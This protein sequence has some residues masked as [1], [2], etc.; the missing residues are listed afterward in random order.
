MR[1]EVLR[2]LDIDGGSSISAILDDL[3]R[4]HPEPWTSDF[5]A[6]VG[7]GVAF[8]TFAYD[9]D[10]VSMEIAKYA[11][12]FEHLLPGVPIHC[13]AGTFGDKADVV[14]DRSWRRFEL[15]GADGWD[16]WD[17]GKWFARLFYE[18]LPADSQMSSELAREMW[19]QALVLAEQLV[20]YIEDHEIGLLF[21]VNTNS[22]PGNLAFGLA[23]VLAAET[24]GRVVI[25][26]N[27]DFYWE[28][29][30]AGCKRNP[31]EEPGP[32]DHFFRNHDNEAF[33]GFFQRIYPWNGRRWAQLNI[34]SLQNR[35][36]ID[37][38]HFRPDRVF[39]VG[40][41]LDTEFFR[42]C[43][44]DDKRE[45]RHK[46]SRVLGGGP[47]I[48]TTSIEDFRLNTRSWMTDQRP[49][50]CGS[51]EAPT[52]DITAPGALYLLQPTR[53]VARKRIWRDCDLIGALL[54]HGPF[55]DAFERRPDLTLTLHIT[56]PVPIE[57][58]PCL[59]RV[60]DAFSAVLDDVPADIGRRL[61]LALSAGC[62][63]DPTS[64]AEIGIVDI[65]QLADLVVFPSLTEGRGL[66]IVEASAAGVPIVCS[67]YEPHEVF[68]EVVG[69]HLDDA[70]SIRYE[71]FPPGEFSDQLLDQL[72]T[73]LLDPTSQTERIDHNHAAVH[74]R[75][76]LD[77]LQESFT[78]V[79]ERLER[80]VRG[81]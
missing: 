54:R 23:I 4:H 3:A 15:P 21:T 29:G 50:V 2:E 26:N 43:T 13:L 73:I 64:D 28:G 60:V 22:N 36:L 68:A 80:T 65:Y 32:R 55:R 9:I 66:P 11:R 47:Q 49:V 12:C 59:E 61:F 37:R 56:G 48:E 6:T 44:A 72:T 17:D 8:V 40:T 46:M 71:D 27:H 51:D 76:S 57:H 52:L 45:Y 69:L 67:H 79:L 1:F 7:R 74:R 14:L 41:G 31:G 70:H 24:T 62:Q 39:T 34:N 20:R 19:R 81:H 38:F 5:R 33:F 78:E 63:T 35:R 77:V 16:K 30:K 75:Y 53:I 25:N 10:G 42:P 18:D 58:R